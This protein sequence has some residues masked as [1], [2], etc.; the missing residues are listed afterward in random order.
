MAGQC[1][2]VDVDCVLVTETM[3]AILI[4]Q[5]GK[6]HWLPR[7]ICSHISKGPMNS[8]LEREAVVT[9]AKWKADQEGLDY[10][11]S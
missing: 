7:S 2:E 4:M 9:I 1:E 10:D 3:L 5:D 8:N 11:I 6:E